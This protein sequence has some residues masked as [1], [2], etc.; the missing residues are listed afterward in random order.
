MKFKAGDKVRVVCEQ[1]GVVLEDPTRSE[2]SVLVRFGT[3]IA[4]LPKDGT[5]MGLNCMKL[6]I[7]D[8]D[9]D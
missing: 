3:Q 7:A 6:V 4:R 2:F 1:D 9:E 8:D 5:L